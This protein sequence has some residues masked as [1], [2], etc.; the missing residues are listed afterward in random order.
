MSLPIVRSNLVI[1]SDPQIFLR[2][3]IDPLCL[4]GVHD[5]ALVAPPLGLA[6]GAAHH[7]QGVLQRLARVRRLDLRSVV[8]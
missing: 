1:H 8:D 7:H 6:G 2:S 4:L 3:L 5:G